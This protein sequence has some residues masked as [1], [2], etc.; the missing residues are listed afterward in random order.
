MTER[1]RIA[2]TFR[3]VCFDERTMRTPMGP[4]TQPK[5]WELHDDNGRVL[6]SGPWESE[7]S[8]TSLLQMAA[9]YIKEHPDGARNI[10]LKAI[11]DHGAYDTP[12]DEEDAILAKLHRQAWPLCL[13][14]NKHHQPGAAHVAGAHW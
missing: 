7:A 2:M 12:Q 4:L 14:C 1:Q 11:Q 6:G 13:V 5:H 3:V 8:I 9:E 10:A